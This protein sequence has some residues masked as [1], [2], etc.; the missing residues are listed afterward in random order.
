MYFEQETETHEM[1]GA[2][3]K[4][5]A[6]QSGLA[7]I[8]GIA[9]FLLQDHVRAIVGAGVAIA[10]LILFVISAIKKFHVPFDISSILFYLSF[11]AFINVPKREFFISLETADPYTWLK[12]ILRLSVLLFFGA[13]FFFI[14]K[15]PL[16]SRRHVIF[17]IVYAMSAGLSTVYSSHRFLTVTRFVELSSFI[18]MAMVIVAR[19]RAMDE[20]FVRLYFG[21]SLIVLFVWTIYF[22]DPSYVMKPRYSGGQTVFQAFGGRLIDPNLLSSIAGMLL[23]VAVNRLVNYK[24]AVFY[25]V[26]HVLSVGVLLVTLYRTFGRGA[27]LGT[28]MGVLFVVLSKRQARV[29]RTVS[30]SA[31]LLPLILFMGSFPFENILEWVSKGDSMDS[32]ISA[33]GRIPV[34][35]DILFYLFPES[36]L[37]GFGFQTMGPDGIIFYSPSGLAITMAHNSFIQTLVGMGLVGLLCLLLSLLFLFKAIFHS[38]SDRAGERYFYF[39]EVISV[40]IVI[41]F[42]SITDYGIAGLNNPVMLAF[43]VLMFVV[44]KYGNKPMG[45]TSVFTLP[46]FPVSSKGN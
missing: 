25:K 38:L 23:V 17:L 13:L 2:T 1:N 19:A 41:L 12:I 31:M 14:K 3:A 35:R 5:V 6:I 26:F 28:L 22:I 33:T 36:P 42:D 9:V 30:L 29:I 43:I 40:M 20:V 39:V 44:A 15:R 21:L 16:I 37:I 24:R 27:I 7:V 46:F 11:L 45:S 34:W 8:A 10:L 4:I 32:M 18:L